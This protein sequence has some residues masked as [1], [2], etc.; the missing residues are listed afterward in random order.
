MK[1]QNVSGCFEAVWTRCALITVIL[2]VAVPAHAKSD[3]LNG[4]YLTKDDFVRNVLSFP[5]RNEG[6]WLKVD[7]HESVIISR[8]DTLMRFKHHQLYG[9]LD[10]GHKYFRWGSRRKLFTNAGYYKVVDTAGLIIL[11]TK[12]K[13][14]KFST[15]VYKY[16]REIGAKRKL[17]TI[18]NLS[19]DFKH[20]PSFIEAI[21][22]IDRTDKLYHIT[23]GSTLVNHAYMEHV[24]PFDQKRPQEIIKTVPSRDA[25]SKKNNTKK[26]AGAMLYYQWYGN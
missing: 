21:R 3:R 18:G 15:T 20:H 9:Y 5:S 2:F 10:N 6:D 26:V 12:I 11:H 24:K 19:K 7:H 23:N 25:M 13:H 8:N 22:A 4:V 16:S 1:T 14:S 17:L